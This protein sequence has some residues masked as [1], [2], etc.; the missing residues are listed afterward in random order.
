MTQYS[1]LETE[2]T[3]YSNFNTKVVEFFIQLASD[4]MPQQTASTI[5][6]A[7]DTFV[8]NTIRAILDT[9]SNISIIDYII[10]TAD[11]SRFNFSELLTPEE[12]KALAQSLILDGINGFYVSIWRLFC[13][14]GVKPDFHSDDWLQVLFELITDF[15]KNYKDIAENADF[16]K[17]PFSK[18]VS[19]IF[20]NEALNI[21]FL[22]DF[23]RSKDLD[24]QVLHL[25]NFVDKETLR[26]VDTKNIQRE[27]NE[28]RKRQLD[29]VDLEELLP[30]AKHF[31][32]DEEGADVPMAGVQEE[33]VK[34]FDQ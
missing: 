33:L 24:P 18:L 10:E 34:D 27:S 16:K 4:I 9:S 22:Y 17:F 11:P 29:D 25:D 8:V 5:L 1:T 23:M 14:M 2:E 19:E 15:N 26:Q 31:K 7:D 32:D 20:S 6:K 12:Q 30:A 3:Q 13:D 21:Q 28:S